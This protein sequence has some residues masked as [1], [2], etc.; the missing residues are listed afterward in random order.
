MKEP[1]ELAGLGF[2]DRALSIEHGGGD[3]ARPENWNQVALPELPLLHQKLQ[4]RQWS[5]LP[6]RTHAPVVILDRQ[7]EQLAEQF[8]LRGWIRLER[9]LFRHLC[10][11]V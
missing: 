5:R 9:K 8:F 7:N 4:H 6:F 2:A 11:A 1:G 10:V 3:A